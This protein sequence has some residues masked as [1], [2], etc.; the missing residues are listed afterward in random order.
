MI[1]LVPMPKK[2]KEEH[3]TSA[4]TAMEPELIWDAAMEPEYYR[5][6]V[7]PDGITIH[8]S[9]RA[10]FFYGE[11]TL[12]QLRFLSQGKL[13]SVVIEDG[14]AYPYR[15]F[16][17]DTARHFVEFEE[18]KRMIEAAAA[19]KLNKFHWHFSDDQGWRIEC[20]RFP[21]LHEIGARRKGD[22]FGQC[23]SDE[24][25]F[26]YYTREQVKELVEF[27]AVRGIE[28][29]PEVDIPGHVTAILAAYPELSCTGEAMEVRTGPGIFEEILCPGKEE[30]FSF[31][32]ELL[33]D[34]CE[35]FPG[36]YFHIGGDETP[37]T[38]WKACP[39]CKKRM[40]QEGLSD[41]RQ[42]Q[43][44]MANRAAAH[45]KE[46]GRTAVA[47]NEAAIGGNLSPEIMVQLWNDDPDDPSLH[48][49]GGELDENGNVTSPNQGIGARIIQAGGDVI[50]SNMLGSYC[51]YPHAF[52][53]AEKVYNAAVIPQKCED[54]PEKAKEHVKGVECLLW[55]EHIRTAE[56]LEAL[57]WPRFAAKAEI[58]W[59]G[60][61][62][63][64]YQEFEQRMLG[65]FPYLKKLIPNATDPEGWVPQGERAAAE[66]MEFAKNY[67]QEEIG[68]Y[69]DAQK[70]V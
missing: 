29:I 67:T 22:H 69:A 28:I 26:Y 61:G 68:G 27:C 62:D 64:T 40:E 70:E 4:S 45:L 36:K 59:C 57:A 33:D 51:D 18:L 34:L 60:E 7:S 50:M 14:P 56:K 52:I 41:V 42:L 44:Y 15:C 54:F 20:R 38:R 53:S 32:F 48:A 25:E 19:F 12:E 16:H 35:L 30:T 11:K 46:L 13:P 3:G 24:E 1:N 21:R 8:A 9:G 55:T 39:Y 23:R 49:L 43:G 2:I 63:Y 66:M 31:I 58:G 17:I 65:L 6:T 5:L 37:K 10:G 47:W